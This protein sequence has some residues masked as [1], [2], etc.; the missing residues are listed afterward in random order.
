MTQKLVEEVEPHDTFRKLE[1]LVNSNCNM[2]YNKIH[3]QVYRKFFELQPKRDKS[4][5]YVN[6]DID[7]EIFSSSESG[8]DYQDTL[9]A[10]NF[11]QFK[12]QLVEHSIPKEL[13]KIL[14]NRSFINAD[15][16]SKYL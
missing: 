6:D 13:E 7:D 12:S 8:S 16:L 4:D 9:D 2:Q 14:K 5:A 11:D 10:I 1:S 15:E 3:L